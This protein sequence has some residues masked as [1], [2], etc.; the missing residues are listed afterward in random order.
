MRFEDFRHGLIKPVVATFYHWSAPEERPHNQRLTKDSIRDDQVFYVADDTHT[1]AS[2]LVHGMKLYAVDC[3]IRR[4]FP[5]FEQ[6]APVEAL[7]DITQ[8]MMTDG[9]FDCAIYTPHSFGRGVREM[10]LFFPREQI[11]SIREVQGVPVT[12]LQA[13]RRNAHV[14][15]T[16][17]RGWDTPDT[18]PILDGYGYIDGN[19]IDV[20]EKETPPWEEIEQ[21]SAR[22]AKNEFHKL[23]DEMRRAVNE[24]NKIH[25]PVVPEQTPTP[26]AGYAERV[27][28]IRK[29]PEPFKKQQASAAAEEGIT[30]KAD[31]LF[32]DGWVLDHTCPLD[33]VKHALKADP[34]AALAMAG[35]EFTGVDPE[36]WEMARRIHKQAALSEQTQ[37]LVKRDMKRKLHKQG[38]PRAQ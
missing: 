15:F 5:M 26:G 34:D 12:E 33:V 38:E 11:I 32:I 21:R 27:I 1:W 16:A 14:N 17:L 6:L 20:R 19:P 30:L 22:L 3:R 29:F 10:A 23:M 4:P 9:D 2:P 8:E 18:P 37:A 25:T 7:T 13:A 36:V 31:E 35:V 24:L 28:L